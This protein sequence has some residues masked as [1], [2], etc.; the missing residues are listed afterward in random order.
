MTPSR[1][2]VVVAVV[3]SLACFAAVAPAGVSSQQPPA[4]KLVVIAVVD[5]LRPDYLDR[6]RTHLSGGF[7]RLLREGAV[8]ENAAYPYLNTVTCAGHATIGTGALPFRHGMILNAWYDRSTRSS[9]SCTDDGSVKNLSYAG[10]EGSGHS[11][12]RLLVQT[13]ADRI[14][15]RGR[16]RVVAVSL[17]PRSAIMLAGHG[18]DAVL[19]FDERGGFATSTAFARRPVPFVASFLEQNPVTADRGRAWERALP[20]GEYHGEDDVAFEQPPRGW[21]RTFPHQLDGEGS[22]SPAQFF[23]QW[24]RTPYADEYLARVAMHA[25]DALKLGRGRSTDFLGISFSTLD[26]VGHGFGPGSHE[27][28]DVVLRLDRT[29]GQLLDHL[30]RAVGK[31][32]YVLAL[33]SDHGVSSVPETVAGAGR[34]TSTEIRAVVDAALT[35]F[36]G[37][38]PAPPAKPGATNAARGSYVSYSAYTD[39]Y[40]SEGVME[41]LRREPKALAA[42]LDALRQ[43][44]GMTHAFN[45][46]DLIPAE[47]RASDEP[48]MRAAALNYHP[49]RSGDIVIVP[50]EHWILSSAVATHGTLHAYDQ[51]VPVIFYGAGVAAGRHQVTATPADIAPTLGRLARLPVPEIDGRALLDAPAP[52]PGR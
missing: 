5:Q 28:Q 44:P 51:R 34:H 37:P 40:L 3:A 39:L 35:P 36:L 24:A 52:A 41:R 4:P 18:G 20:A 2:A 1:R 7:D 25:V 12:S 32:N 42:V 21:T 9:T 13:L 31:G 8:F 15:E 14:R 27:V 26:L 33:S 6:H 48:A 11:A 46:D 23:S 17:K 43:M 49:G 50:R 10:V 16:G 19:W 38:P 45:G 47:A 29:L 22:A 30:D